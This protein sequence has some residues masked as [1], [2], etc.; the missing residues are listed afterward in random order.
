MERAIAAYRVDYLG[1]WLVILGLRE[2]NGQRHRLV[3]FSDALGADDF[4]RLR[5]LLRT[6][7]GASSAGSSW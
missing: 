2:A 1:R 5:V 7:R 4:R 3:I 6:E